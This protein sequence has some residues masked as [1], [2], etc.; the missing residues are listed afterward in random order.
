MA[1]RFNMGVMVQ[2]GL[3]YSP[4]TFEQSLFLPLQYRDREDR[5]A[6]EMSDM[7]VKMSNI[8]VGDNEKAKEYYNQ[9]VNKTNEEIESIQNNISE[10]GVLNPNTI[11]NFRNLKTRYNVETSANGRLGQLSKLATEVQQ[12]RGLRLE[13]NLTEGY[14]AQTGLS[15]YQNQVDAQYNGINWDRFQNDPTYSIGDFQA[16]YAPKNTTVDD[17]V[18]DMSGLIGSVTNSYKGNTL[19]P[20]IDPTTGLWTLTNT[21]DGRM[22]STNEPNLEALNQSIRLELDNLDSP[23]M[24]AEIYRLGRTKE[25]ITPEELQNVRSR[26][27]QKLT[28]NILAMTTTIDSVDRT[29]SQQVINTLGG[30]PTSASSS[31][32]G[33]NDDDSDGYANLDTGEAG[34]RNVD[35]NNPYTKNI[36][37]IASGKAYETLE[38]MGNSGNLNGMTEKEFAKVNND[39]IAIERIVTKELSEINKDPKARQTL[40]SNAYSKNLTGNYNTL[41]QKYQT[42]FK[43]LPGTQNSLMGS[44]TSLDRY[45]LPGMNVPVKNVFNDTNA[46]NQFISNKTKYINEFDKYKDL[47]KQV[48][49]NSIYKNEIGLFYDATMSANP[50]QNHLIAVD[51]NGKYIYAT[52]QSDLRQKLGVTQNFINFQIFSGEDNVVNKLAQLNGTDS[53]TM[54]DYLKA[55][56]NKNLYQKF[57][58]AMKSAVIEENNKNLSKEGL[59]YDSDTFYLGQGEQ[60][61]KLGERVNKVLNTNMGTN[62][63]NIA[64]N[65]NSILMRDGNYEGVNDA[66]PGEKAVADLMNEFPDAKF[67]F[68][69]IVTNGGDSNAEIGFKVEYKKGTE[70]KTA[71]LYIPYTGD[72]KSTGMESILKELEANLNPYDSARIK[73]IR[74]NTKTQYLVVDTQRTANSGVSKNQKNLITRA[75]KD[76]LPLETLNDSNYKK[77][78]SFFTNADK[79]NIY[80][81]NDGFYGLTTKSG[82][83]N[84]VAMSVNQYIQKETA[85]NAINNR[86][87]GTTGYIDSSENYNSPE[88]QT[89]LISEM[90][91]LVQMARK[92]II[93]IPTVDPN[94]YQY[95]N[96]FM[97]MME[98]PSNGLNT[99]LQQKFLSAKALFDGIKNKEILHKNKLKL[100]Y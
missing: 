27:S 14:D 85:I 56:T 55:S 38:A 24:Q 86:S 33:G 19:N 3:T 20:I 8:N 51:N 50:S 47:N 69:N 71:F 23:L 77:V 78:T 40:Y 54:K 66:F 91:N 31:G 57:D 4:E 37:D 32:S 59:K 6:N 9:F 96:D 80:T 42:A 39:V 12:Q 98:Q 95:F 90:Y 100:L 25:T 92:G 87:M 79:A 45:K 16:G 11:N 46:Y 26:L 30:S 52:S 68:Q 84:P 97:M 61:L 22:Y 64:V 21:N 48:M 81:T 28:Y 10:K 94:N 63:F 67:S 82:N 83:N 36:A 76:I 65:S 44:L 60:S 99:S 62:L 15:N 58:G 5:L 1:D 74:D 7:I 70:N 13:R 73:S 34:Y 89:L 49:T 41:D 35:M 29:Q 53:K 93:K 43:D 72:S 2:P 18:K 88:K 17:I 75:G